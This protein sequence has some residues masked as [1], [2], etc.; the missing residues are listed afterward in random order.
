MFTSTRGAGLGPRIVA[1]GC[2]T[3]A[4]VCVAGCTGPGQ[5]GPTDGG[6]DAPAA[7]VPL[8][9]QLPPATKTV[10]SITWNLPLGEPSTIDP[11]QSVDYGPDFMVSNM[12][13]PLM[14]QKPD[15]SIEPNL[16]TPTQVDPL[17]LKFTLRPG[18]T[19]WDGTPLTAQDVV[20]SMTRI[21]KDENTPVN[22]LYG[23][24][25]SIDA[26]RPDTVVIKFTQPD[27]LFLKEMSTP[28]GM[29]VEKAFTEQRR[30]QF[31]TSQGGLMCSGPYQLQQWQAG[32]SITL[33]KNP[34][35][36][37]TDLTPKVGTV[38]V[39]FVT[40]TSA[41]TQRLQSGEIDGA[42]ELPSSVIPSLQSNPTGTLTFGPSPQSFQLSVTHPGGQIA[43]PDLRHAIWQA[44]DRQQIA[45]AAFHGAAEPNYTNLAKTAWD[46][47]ATE[48]YQR[49]YQ[50]WVD[51]NKYDP[52]A[53][54]ALVA[55][56]GYDGQPLVLG[57]LAGDTTHSTVAQILQQQLAAVGIKLTINAMQPVQ[58]S[59][60]TSQASG[61]QGLDLMLATNFNQVPDPLEFM[62]LNMT[63]GGAYN[64]ADFDGTQ[65]MQYLNQAQETADPK[66]R[67]ELVVDAQSLYEQARGST[68]LV[69]VNEVSFLNNRLG[70]A[71]T[72]FAY[73]FMPSLAY[74]GGK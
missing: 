57:T 18:V 31:G 25:A 32:N 36:W 33:T 37:N 6:A 27:E 51:A 50:Q 22:Y 74:I 47:A 67:A 39:E 43:N 23:H 72:S 58:Y 53:A 48:V 20:F 40:D 1:L 49:E 26:T 5:N 42:Y 44:V 24:V 15:F 60:A 46:P 56:S 35:Y 59:T 11:A 73:L 34:K 2:S 63:P 4:L 19:F 28:A 52:Q 55:K 64:Y 14:R 16:A 62:G 10:D 68:S 38:R 71:V 29:V 7:P 69:T 54:K 45:Q 21:W 66:A 41:L 65:A 9:S 3:L 13:D 70:G 30:D 61:R 17:T 8:T 12:C